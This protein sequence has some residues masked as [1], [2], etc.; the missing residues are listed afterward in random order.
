MQTDK[1]CPFK[2]DPIPYPSERTAT[3]EVSVL[4]NQPSATYTITVFVK[5]K[6]QEDG[7]F[8][9][10]VNPQPFDGEVDSRQGGALLYVVNVWDSRPT[11]LWVAA[12]VCA[13]IGPVLLVAFLIYERGVLAKQA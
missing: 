12:L 2:S 13:F 6:G 11:S 9:G 5:C 7:S 4:E 8:C 1:S 3:A 10:V